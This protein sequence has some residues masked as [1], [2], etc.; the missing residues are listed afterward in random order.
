MREAAPLSDTS[1][2]RVLAIVAHAHAPYRTALHL[3]IARE[4]KSVR[5]L[6]VFTH[7]AGTGTPWKLEP[8]AEMNSVSFGPGEDPSRAWA[9]PAHEWRKAG[10]IC[11]FFVEQKVTDVVVCGYNDAGRL[12]IIEFCRRHGIRCFLFGDSN[13]RSDQAQGAKRAIKSLAIH[14]LMLQLDGVLVC[15]SLGRAFF[16]GYGAAADRIFYWPYEPDYARIEEL[17]PEFVADVAWR[18]SL[19]PGRRRIVFSGRLVPVKRVDLLLR[20]FSAIAKERPKWDLVI[21]GDGPLRAELDAMITPELEERVIRLGFQGEQDVVSAV[22]RNADLLC[23]P[24]DAEPWALVVNE[25][26]AAG[27]AIVT[28]DVVGASAEIVRHNINGRLFRA[29]DVGELTEALLAC[30]AP[31]AIDRMKGESPRVLA[32]WRSSG[33]PIAGLSAALASPRGRAHVLAGLS[34][35]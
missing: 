19:V 15:G 18:F 25:A 32:R 12:R 21:C 26:A 3:R 22:Y 30:T 23:L 31:E 10:A 11:D 2:S 8:P 34:R 4:M 14:A 27:L 9:K 7:D 16:E 17:T 13:T 29:G 33:D 5:L 28:S 35:G 20:A 24:S 1:Q 6:S